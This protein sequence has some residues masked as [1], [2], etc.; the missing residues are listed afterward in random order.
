MSAKLENAWEACLDH[1]DL[2]DPVNARLHSIWRNNWWKYPVD[3]KNSFLDATQ[4]IG[5]TARNIGKPSDHAL[6]RVTV[7]RREFDWGVWL[8]LRAMYYDTIMDE[9]DPVY[10]MG[11]TRLAT[12]LAKTLIDERYPGNDNLNVDVPMSFPPR[13]PN[14]AVS[15]AM[16][17]HKPD[18]RQDIKAQS[19]RS[20]TEASTEACQY[21]SASTF[22]S[23]QSLHT[24][25]GAPDR[26]TASVYKSTATQTSPLQQ[27]STALDS[28]TRL[29]WIGH[30]RHFPFPIGASADVE[31][32][33]IMEQGLEPDQYHNSF[34]PNGHPASIQVLAN[35]KPTVEDGTVPHMNNNVRLGWSTRSSRRHQ[36]HQQLGLYRKA[37]WDR[38]LRRPILHNRHQQPAAFPYQSIETRPNKLR[39]STTKGTIEQHHT[40]QTSPFHMHGHNYDT[41]PTTP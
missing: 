25:R 4:K 6:W 9:T 29:A 11:R 36:H 15:T 33:H 37:S 14:W 39:P 17:L 8:V 5:H 19:Y 1:L 40:T 38:K 2:G 21:G 28:D 41:V 23:N 16:G 30:Q 27:Q 26:Q 31:N 13:P 32:F 7:T 12:G 20:P 34:H 22:E 3:I 35:G 18:Y 24:S 10:V